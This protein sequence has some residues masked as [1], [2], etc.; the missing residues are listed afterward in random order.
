MFWRRIGQ[1]VSYS[2]YQRS[3]RTCPFPESHQEKRTGQ[4]V[5]GSISLPAEKKHVISTS[6]WSGEQ[7]VNLVNEY[8]LF[9]PQ[10]V[11]NLGQKGHGFSGFLVGFYGV[12]FVQ[13]T[14]VND[15]IFL[16]S[17]QDPCFWG[18]L[19]IG[20]DGQQHFSPPK[21]KNSKSNLHS[22]ARE[23]KCT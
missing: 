17:N 8:M 1:V 19:T 11:L 21:A 5:Q 4:S 6:C 2:K 3:S 9:S 13:F 15:A 23:I 12:S 16:L 7:K 20:C 22:K 10:S 18:S 14:I